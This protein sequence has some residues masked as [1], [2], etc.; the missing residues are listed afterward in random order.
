MFQPTRPIRPPRQNSL[1]V[2][3][4]VAL[5]VTLIT[6]TLLMNE[7]SLIVYERPPMYLEPVIEESFIIVSVTVALLLIYPMMPPTLSFVETTVR[8]SISELLTV[9]G[10]PF[11]VPE[12][13]PSSAPPV[14]LTFFTV[15]LVT[16]DA[17]R[18]LN[19]TPPP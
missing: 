16:V 2:P 3:V 5:S 6:P 11:D 17:L 9:T 1:P 14:I 13:P 4:F 19:M 12:I 18:T 15:A 10:L 7:P 8:F